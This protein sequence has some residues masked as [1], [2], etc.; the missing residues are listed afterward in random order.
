MDS[1]APLRQRI[2]E[3]LMESQY[4]PPRQMLEFQRSQLAQLLRHAKATVPFYKTRLDPVF[5][6]NGDVDWNRWHEIPI[7]TR[8]DLRERR[9]ELL[10]QELPSGHGPT[11][12]FSTSGSSGVPITVT[13]TAIASVARSAATQRMRT[14]HKLDASKHFATFVFPHQLTGTIFN[15]GDT[16]AWSLELQNGGIKNIK[17]NLFLPDARKLEILV[18]ENVGSLS[19]L[20]NTAEILAY[21]NNKLGKPLRLESFLFY[22]Q[23]ISDEQR[24]KVAESFGARC[25]SIYSSKEAGVMAS[26]CPTHNH[27]HIAGELVFLE[28]LNERNLPCLAGETGR[29]VVTPFHSTAQPLIRYEQGDLATLGGGCGCGSQLPVLL[30][31]DGRQDPIFRFPDRL[32]NEVLIDKSMLQKT[33]RAAAIQMAQTR[34]LKFEIRYVADADA[35]PG[36]KAKINKH[37]RLVL[38]PELNFEYKRLAEIPRNAGGKQQRFVREF[39]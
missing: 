27:F 31:I 8:A 19:H 21:E 18:Q 7:L 37:L 30:R 36:A 25:I 34:E 1:T 20:P 38:H 5:S 4:W 26:Q 24:Q 10:A 39:A 2:Y 6:E 32:G 11:R 22:G 35:T 29:V 33:L 17:I 13:A 28:V 9:T 15:D 12:D 23:H 14:L 16:P 3:M